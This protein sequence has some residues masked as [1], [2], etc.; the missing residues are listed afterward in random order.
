MKIDRQHVHFVGIGGIGMSAVAHMAA[1]CGAI[2]SGCDRSAGAATEAL[3]ARGCRICVGHDPAHLEGVAL[4]VRSSAIDKDHPEIQAARERG[5]PVVGRA[6]M[7]ARLGNG[8]RVIGIAGA[9][10]KT[11]TTWIVARLLLEAR[12]DP[13]V[14]VGGI[15]PELGGNYRVGAGDYMVTEVDESDGSLLEFQPYIS[16]VTNVEL[17]HVDRYPDLAAVQKTF[18]DYLRGTQPDGCVV[19]CADSE[20]ALESLDGTGRRVRTYGFA[21][22]AEIRGAN[23]RVEGARSRLD[24]ERPQGPLADLEV[25]LPG[26]HNAQNALAAVAVAAELNIDDDVLRRALGGLRGVGRRLEEKGRANGVWVLDDYAHHPTEVAA[27]LDAMRGMADGRLIGVFQP[28]RYSRTQQLGHAFGACF[29]ALD[30]LVLL[31]IY[32]A[33][34]GPIEGVTSQI[35]EDAVRARGKVECVTCDSLDEAVGTLRR[36]LE[37]GD[38]LVT[39]GAGNVYQVGEALLAEREECTVS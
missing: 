25:G 17:E 38:T 34:E 32:G 15:V 1:E 3:A 10:G 27:T 9:H 2:V 16:V 29:D 11:T 24:V 8:H 35:I 26:R 18:R 19:I 7:L 37:P 30:R 23:F 33:D 5:I 39:L 21:P 13:S 22:G 20:A 12:F 6:R 4:V 28:H 31:P 36:I 14:M